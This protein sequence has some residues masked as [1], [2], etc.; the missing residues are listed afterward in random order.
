MMRIVQGFSGKNLWV[1]FSFRLALKNYFS[2]RKNP[3]L[4]IVLFLEVFLL[5]FVNS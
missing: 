2:S 3:I 4:Q 5:L 1:V